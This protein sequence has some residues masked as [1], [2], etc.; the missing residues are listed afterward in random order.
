M[1]VTW[2]AESVGGYTSVNNLV[3]LQFHGLVSP[4]D[5]SRSTNS[6]PAQTLV[7]I[8]TY[9]K[10]YYLPGSQLEEPTASEPKSGN[11]V[12]TTALACSVRP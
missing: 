1:A 4:S 9:H 2:P 5:T 8:F 10:R 3:F 7:K 6:I 12:T 11:T